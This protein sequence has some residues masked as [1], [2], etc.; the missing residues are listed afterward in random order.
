LFPGWASILVLPGPVGVIARE[1]EG[2]CE[3]NTKKTESESEREGA[4][5]RESEREVERGIDRERESER[6]RERQMESKLKR[7]R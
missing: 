5:A 1:R 6:A 3:S 7:E 4:R 2:K